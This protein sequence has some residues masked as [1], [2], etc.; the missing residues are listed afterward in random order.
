MGKLKQLA[1][2]IAENGTKVIFRMLNGECIALFPELP[3]NNSCLTCLNYM[4]IGQHGIGNA[5]VTGTKPASFDHYKNLLSELTNIGYNLKIVSRF[6]YRMDQ[7]RIAE[8]NRHY[9]S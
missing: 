4:R 5:N 1:Q 7:N 2:E 9:K 3:G 8:L 6:S